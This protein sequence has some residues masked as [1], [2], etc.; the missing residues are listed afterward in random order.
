MSMRY[1][2]HT[3]LSIH[4]LEPTIPV[5]AGLGVSDLIYRI[6]PIIRLSTVSGMRPKHHVCIERCSGMDH[7]GRQYHKECIYTT[8]STA[9]ALQSIHLCSTHC[10]LFFARRYFPVYTHFIQ[11]RL[12]SGS[13]LH[14]NGNVCSDGAMGL[15]VAFQATVW[16]TLGDEIAQALLSFVCI[17]RCVWFVTW[18]VKR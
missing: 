14:R 16:P 9:N 7:C 12:H 11:L 18:R 17:G 5:T 8:S 3:R 15:N 1:I 6:I 13:L 10:I 2:P 4:D